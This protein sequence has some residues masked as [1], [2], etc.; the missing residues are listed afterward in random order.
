MREG[1]LY[2]GTELGVFMSFDDGAHWQP[3]QLNL[4]VT[5]ISRSRGKR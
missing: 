2:A 3:L 4:P 1:L 5:P